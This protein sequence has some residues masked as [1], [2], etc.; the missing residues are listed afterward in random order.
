MKF[1][2]RSLASPLIYWI[3]CINLPL[4]S[5]IFFSNYSLNIDINY[6]YSR[7]FPSNGSK[8]T[9]GAY[10]SF[11]NLHKIS[12]VLFCGPAAGS[13][14]I[15]LSSQWQFYSL[16]CTLCALEWMT[17]SSSPLLQLG[18]DFFIF[19]LESASGIISKHD[20]SVSAGSWTFSSI[21]HSTLLFVLFH[22]GF[23]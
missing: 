11:T 4:G 3:N 22:Q 9:C 15:L 2:I 20:G 16:R 6:V 23:L 8:S 5:S 21:S 18:Y 1:L 7:G 13:F 10:C 17:I 12:A 19:L 14:C